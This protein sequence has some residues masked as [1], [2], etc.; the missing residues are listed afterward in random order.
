MRAAY[1]RELKSRK[2]DY[3]WQMRRKARG[4]AGRSDAPVKGAHQT[5]APAK[6]RGLGLLVRAV[7]SPHLI[8]VGF[9][10]LSM[11]I[12]LDEDVATLRDVI[13]SWPDAGA[14]VDRSAIATH[15]VQSGNMRAADLLNSYPATTAIA[16]NGADEREWLIALEQYVAR[17]DA[18]ASGDVAKAEV[19]A[20][21][22]NWRRRRHEVAE[23]EARV[24]RLNEAA[25][26]T[27]QD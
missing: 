18:S 5:S 19:T 10:M 1:E 27:D 16:P 15:L 12:F 13:I 9:E 21:P 7:D 11:A 14:G 2:N 24:A 6:T 17:D 20:S 26:Q 4:S 8:D 25:E 3:L 23:R 22:E